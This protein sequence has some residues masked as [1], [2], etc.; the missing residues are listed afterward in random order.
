VIGCRVRPRAAGLPH[1]RQRFPGALGAVDDE[2]AQRGPPDLF[3]VTGGAGPALR[4]SG[5]QREW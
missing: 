2:R 1:H 4:S 5:G 3:V